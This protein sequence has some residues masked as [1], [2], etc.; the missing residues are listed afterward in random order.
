M[1]KMSNTEKKVLP[2]LEPIVAER[3]LE[4]VDLEFV[5]E[6]ANWYLRV[7]VDKDG[8]VDITDCEFVSR[9]LDIKLDEIDPIE[10]AY[11]LEVS[12]P[13]LD[14]PL[15]KDADF[16]KFQGEIIDVKLYKAKDGK[17]QYQGEL[18]SLENG[19]LSIKEGE[20]VY[21]FEQK[22]V[23]SVRLAVIF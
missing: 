2:I 17:K 12:S 7:Y 16:V 5:K 20:T 14:R 8:G 21:T 1:A 22:E 11:Y 10:Q 13:G 23:A 18:L 15:K 19:V 9:A 6:G 3:G 4:L